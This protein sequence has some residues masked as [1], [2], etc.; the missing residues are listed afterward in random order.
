MWKTSTTAAALACAAT[1]MGCATE[2]TTDRGE[3]AAEAR[4]FTLQ[5]DAATTADT[6]I[7]A[8]L[9]AGHDQLAA[10]CE[11]AP[12]AAVRVA[13]P[14][15]SG[16][17]AIV[18][19]ATLVGE[20]GE[21]SAALTRELDD[22]PIDEAQQ[23]ITPVGLACGVLTALLGAATTWSCEKYPDK[24]CPWGTLGGTTTVGIVCMFL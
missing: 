17:E 20:A 5:L 15:A 4:A 2:T 7:P 22:G 14:L 9:A 12:G 8:I 18:P 6:V 23:K 11:A 3:P 21:T 16:R 13:N 10:A 19:C 24:I 1:W